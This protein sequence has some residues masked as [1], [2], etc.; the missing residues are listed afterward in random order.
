MFSKNTSRA[1]FLLSLLSTPPLLSI[2]FLLLLVC[3]ARRELDENLCGFLG[4]GD[5]IGGDWGIRVEVCVW[6]G[7][8]L[9]KET[10][11]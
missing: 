4:E 8:D 9:M 5:E 7:D 2:F 10:Q 1:I 11:M 3:R 6:E